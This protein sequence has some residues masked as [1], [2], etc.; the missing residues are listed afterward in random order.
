[1][2]RKQYSLVFEMFW[3]SLDGYFPKGSKFEAYREFNKLECDQEDAVFIASRYNELVNAKRAVL[4][5]G[6]WTAPIKHVSRYLKGEEFDN[7]ISERPI[8]RRSKDDER[9][10]KYAEFFAGTEEGLGEGL[11]DAGGQQISTGTGNVLY[12]PV[13]DESGD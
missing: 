5:R 4:E 2:K 8:E 6:S 13:L 12:F 10:S 11:G 3:K 7:E 1:M 9:R